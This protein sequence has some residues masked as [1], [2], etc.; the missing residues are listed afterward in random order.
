MAE[1][2]L[3]ISHTLDA[4]EHGSSD[5]VIEAVENVCMNAAAKTND[6]VVSDRKPLYLYMAGS[7]EM[8]VP[9]GV[10]NDEW[11]K[12]WTTGE[13]FFALMIKRIGLEKFGTAGFGAVQFVAQLLDVEADL[14]RVC[15][16][17]A[18]H[19]RW[20]KAVPIRHV[21][22]VV[23]SNFTDDNKGLC[24]SIEDANKIFTSCWQKYN[25]LKDAEITFMVATVS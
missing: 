17:C 15:V 1:L 3:V 12:Q 11:D 21:T 23:P 10:D 2:V 24:S 19:L 6:T 14:E 5:T 8:L 18:S 13:K 16:R 25:I 22:V 4:M 20:K 9:R 7:K